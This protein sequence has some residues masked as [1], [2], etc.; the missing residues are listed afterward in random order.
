MAEGRLI[1]AADLEL[2][3]ASGNVID[4]DLR[5]A[6]MRAEREVIQIALARSNGTLSAAAKLLGI[7]RPTLYG[8]M[9]VHGLEADSARSLE[10]SSGAETAGSK[11]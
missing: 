10:P 3:P 5:S 4:L 9:E 7:S 1:D 6:R 11:R 8:L 2:A